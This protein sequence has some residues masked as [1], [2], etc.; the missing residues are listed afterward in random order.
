[1]QVRLLRSLS[2]GVQ[3]T[4]LWCRPFSCKKKIFYTVCLNSVPSMCVLTVRHNHSHNVI[5]QIPN[6]QLKIFSKFQCLKAVYGEEQFTVQQ[7]FN[8]LSEKC[9]KGLA[10]VFI[11]QR[12]SPSLG[13]WVQSLG[14]PWRKEP[15]DLHKLSS[16]VY[17]CAV[18]HSSH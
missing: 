12:L 15:G 18:T 9:D 10:R 11:G 13:T 17:T 1:M 16:H 2:P 5:L 14:P 4:S 3:V 8:S 7:G 6:L